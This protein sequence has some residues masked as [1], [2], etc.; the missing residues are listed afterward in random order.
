MDIKTLY[1]LIAIADR[2]SFV[3]AGNSIGLSLSA[4]SMQ[5]RALEEEIESTIFDRTRRPPALTDAG[6][7]LVHRARD[8]LAHWESMSASLKQGTAVGLL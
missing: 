4:V 6:L 7:A 1:T 2:G 3:E 5:M 8:L